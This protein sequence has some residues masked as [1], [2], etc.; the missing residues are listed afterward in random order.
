M[1]PTPPI[2]LTM[3]PMTLTSRVMDMDVSSSAVSR[4][5]TLMFGS[6]SF[7]A[8]DLMVS[9]V[10]L[11]HVFRLIATLCE[12]GSVAVTS[13]RVCEGVDVG[14]PVAG[15]VVMEQLVISGVDSL[16][17]AVATAKMDALPV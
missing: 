13:V 16:W 2:E 3:G 14:Q 12:G 8:S 4:M 5:V 11:A 15:D 6:P 1:I 10:D 7:S 17:Q 9:R